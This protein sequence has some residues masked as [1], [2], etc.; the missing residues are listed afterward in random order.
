MNFVDKYFKGKTKDIVFL[1]LKEDYY[2]GN[3]RY[4]NKETP[5]P[6][7]TEDL[8]RK[9]EDKNLGEEIELT[10]IIEG[11]IYLMGADKTFP[12]I[13]EY[14]DFIEKAD[15]NIKEY[16]L[17]NAI[18]KSEEG[19]LDFAALWLRGL[20]YMEENSITAL[21]NYGIVL[22]KIGKIFM[23]EDKEEYALEFIKESTE[24]FEKILKKDENYSLAYY[25]LGFHYKFFQKFLKARLTWNKFLAL[26]EDEILLEE[27]R[28]EISNIRDQAY[29]EIGLS[30]FNFRDYEKALEAL[31]KLLPGHKE[32]W[33]V[34]FLIGQSYAGQGKDKESIKFLKEAL[35]LNDSNSDIYNELGA[36][37]YSMGNIREAIKIFSQ[38]IEKASIDFKLYFN[39]AIAYKEEGLYDLALKDIEF[40]EE[41]RPDER[42]IK[43]E[44]NY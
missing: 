37:H 42:T 27:V 15:L 35:K 3:N 25:K 12:H 14:K 40:S 6:I 21:F 7:I 2:L 32:S 30:Y 8:I 29:F 4:I 9:I 33:N 13:K 24:S 18:N 28:E 34:N 5:L 44:K 36:I 20:L 38:G 23:D 17:S 16:I 11:I 10:A 19:H 43:D 41:I 31:L 22:E 26:S 39:R 1:E